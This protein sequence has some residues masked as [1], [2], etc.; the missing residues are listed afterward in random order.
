MKL[1]ILALAIF[2]LLLPLDNASG[3]SF[4]RK[5]IEKR[6]GFAVRKA[7][8]TSVRIWGFDTINKV[9]ASSQFSGVVV[10]AEGHIFTVAHAVVPGKIYKVFF[11]DGR[12]YLAAGLGRIGFVDKQ[13]MPDIGM[14]KIMDKGIWP[15][16]EIGWSSALK[17]NEPCVSISYP[18]TLDQ[19]LPTVRF[20]RIAKTMNDWGFIE[21]TC[22]MEPG[23]SGG[24]LYDDMGRVIALHSRIDKSEDINLE[25]P[26]DLYR[27]YWTALQKAEDYKALPGQLDEIKTDPLA[28]KIKTIAGLEDLNG[29]FRNYD[30]RYRDKTVWVKSSVKGAEQLAAGTLF[31]PDDSMVKGLNKKGVYV[32]SK[33]SLVGDNA[34]VGLYNGDLMRSKLIARDKE[35]D[36]VLLELADAHIT[37]GGIKLKPL[38]DT[39]SVKFEDIGKFLITPLAGKRSKVGVVSSRN[40]GLPRKFSIGY[41]GAGANFQNEQIIL[42]RIAPGS[43]AEDGKLEL[44]DQI[45]G[46]NG[47]LISRPEQYGNELMKYSAGDSI[48]I[49]GIRKG[50]KYSLMVGIRPRPAMTDHPAENFD[51]GK[52]VVLDGFKRVFAHDAAIRPEECGGP[53]FDAEGR[54]YGINIA[55]F[56]RTS[57]LVMPESVIYDFIYRS[58]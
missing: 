5:D 54:F 7:Y 55:R 6:T 49:E 26:V 36:L 9:Q 34:L 42:T 14:L 39:A 53:V 11:T 43:P 38:S 48:T 15:F 19:R 47:V 29:N 21:S 4:H 52:S 58:W 22:K 32:I 17:V 50:E 40:F 23:D 51:G 46:I 41:F 31:V 56:S 12:E 35:N 45:V 25:V 16:A 33:N 1:Y 2:A 10:S 37:A 30:A 57:T 27:K 20:G 28:G 24:P 44:G 18:E 13:N 3:Q 8:A